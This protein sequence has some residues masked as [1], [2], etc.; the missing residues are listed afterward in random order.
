[1]ST[2]IEHVSPDCTC[3]GKHCN[4][5]SKA[6]CINKFTPKNKYNCKQCERLR[7]RKY[8]EQQYSTVN[9]YKPRKEVVFTNDIEHVTNICNCTG[10]I[11]VICEN[12]LCIG[13]FNKRYPNQVNNTWLR[14][15]CKE[16][17][18]KYASTYHDNNK[19]IH[20]VYGVSY[21]GNNKELFRMHNNKRRVLKQNANGIF[22]LQQWEELK[23]LY[24]YTCLSCGKSEPEIQLEIDHVIPLSKHGSNDISNIQPLCRSCNA[25][26]HN[27]I[28]DYRNQ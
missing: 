20:A 28:V 15:A 11:C 14:S 7:S 5:C 9:L 13:K 3:T 2:E 19:E 21:R 24:N 18:N 27:N 17:N 16:C 1:M 6:L 22:T 4:K 10:K 26:K 25:S 23:Q 8:Y 12:V